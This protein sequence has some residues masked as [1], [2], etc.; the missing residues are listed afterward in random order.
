MKGYL[1]NKEL[2]NKDCYCNP[3]RKDLD[4]LWNQKKRR[5]SASITQ[6]YNII[7]RH[8]VYLGVWTPSIASLKTVATASVLEK[9]FN[10]LATKWKR[11]TGLYSTAVDKIN[12]TYLEIIAMRDDAVPFMLMDMQ[13]P[14]G[15]AH[16]HTALKAITKANPVSLE[17]LNKSK[18]VRQRWVEWGEKNHKI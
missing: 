6:S 17:E 3:S 11:E 2:F 10:E 13:K 4:L 18:I 15:S 8:D 9:Q 1:K 7:R 5:V 14:N 16:W 12:D